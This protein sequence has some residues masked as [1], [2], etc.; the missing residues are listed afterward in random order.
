VQTNRTRT[1]CTHCGRKA[2]AESGSVVI[3]TVL[4]PR[5]GLPTPLTQIAQ[6]DAKS[7]NL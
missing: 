6:N 1:V 3:Y 7:S 4:T 5:L 2:F